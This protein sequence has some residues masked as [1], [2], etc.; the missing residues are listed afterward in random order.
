[1]A[2]QIEEDATLILGALAGAPRNEYVEAPQLAID[3]GLDPDRI[4]DAVALLVEAGRVEWTQVM[5]TAPFDFGDAMITP[6][7]RQD[8][9]RLSPSVPV[10]HSDGS[11]ALP[12]TTIRLFIS[13]SSDDVELARRLVTLFRTAL[14]LS[15]SAIRCSSVDGYRLPGGVHT[16]EQLRREVHDAQAF[17][18]IV[19]SSSVRSLY[20]LFELGARWGAGRQM[21]P[22]LAPGTAISV[23]GGPLAGL[24]A[25]DASNP[26]Q[27][28]QLLSELATALSVSLDGAAAYHELNRAAFHAIDGNGPAGPPSAATP[29]RSGCRCQNQRP[30]PRSRF[31]RRGSGSTT[32]QCLRRS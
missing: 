6:R 10:P 23:L 16:D 27:L 31:P 22:L 5:G 20:V 32:P 30:R 3:T 21:I 26:S 2:T 11:V 8:F 19:S 15:S 12:K 14:N 29:E 17:I 24:N 18:G 25:L 9:Q 7:G 4:N 1:M 13:H 28:H